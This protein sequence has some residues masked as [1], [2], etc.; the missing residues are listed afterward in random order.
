MRRVAVKQLMLVRSMA[1]S[2]LVVYA[3]GR[4]SAE[5]R[6]VAVVTHCCDEKRQTEC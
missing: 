6:D 1:G 2:V 5:F 3:A 4:A